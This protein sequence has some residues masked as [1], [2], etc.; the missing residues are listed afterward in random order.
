[1]RWSAAA[2]SLLIGVFAAL[3]AA[4][5]A[6]GQAGQPDRVPLG[7][8]A[9]PP[10]V[11]LALLPPLDYVRGGGTTWFGP[12][13]RSRE[14]RVLGRATID[15]AVTFDDQTGTVNGAAAAALTRRWPED[16]RGQIA[17][18]HVVGARTVG[19]INGAFLVTAQPGRTSAAFEITMAFP[20][21]R[22]QTFAVFRFLL[23]RP[24]Q[25]DHLVH[26]DVR[27]AS[28]NRGQAFQ[29][30]SNVRLEGNLA[31]KRVTIRRTRARRAVSGTVR[32]AFG[33]PLVGVPVA[34]ERWVGGAW[35]PVRA[36]RTSTRGGYMIAATRLGTY[37][38]VAALS[39]ISVRSVAVTAGR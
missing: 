8:P 9:F 26:G 39:G 24:E 16:Q 15:W 35:R 37:R 23:A 2:L 31:P 30:I 14:G 7:A 36:A 4:Q 12:E 38:T 10:G 29:A 34:L 25:E 18:P 33:H 21:V 11:S 20:I 3:L 28:W 13:Y 32:D 27:A 17:V 5:L 19:T 6:S 1:M 22:P